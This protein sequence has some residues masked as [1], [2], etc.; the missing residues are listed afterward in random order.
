MCTRVLISEE[1]AR[2]WVLQGEMLERWGQK[3]GGPHVLGGWSRRSHELPGGSGVEWAS[4]H[5]L[6]GVPSGPVS[7]CLL[8]AGSLS[9]TPSL[10]WGPLSSGCVGT[11][12]SN[13]G[14]G[15]GSIRAASAPPAS[16]RGGWGPRG[17]RWVSPHPRPQGGAEALGHTREQSPGISL[18]CHL[19]EN[20]VLILEPTL[21]AQREPGAWKSPKRGV[22]GS[23]GLG[24]GGPCRGWGWAESGMV[25]SGWNFP[26]A[27]HGSS[28]FPVMRVL[29]P[30]GT[31]SSSLLRL[32]AVPWGSWAASL[33]LTLHFPQ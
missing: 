22:A 31:P 29:H 21:P 18:G 10:C 26:L 17:G 23:P 4:L 5:L 24:G 20:R 15:T 3:E 25:Q 11:S 14:D 33:A 7:R 8:S 27:S 1:E 6:R 32:Q 19:L 12:C 2:S 28:G 16:S 30:T 13:A 9:E